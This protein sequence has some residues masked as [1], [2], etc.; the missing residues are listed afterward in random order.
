M[1]PNLQS[2]Y[3][4]LTDV[5][6][7]AAQYG[8]GSLL[9][10]AGPG[11]GK[12]RVLTARIVRLLS[13][14]EG[15]SWRIA[16]LTFTTRAADE[17]RERVLHHLPD[18]EDR[19]F[20]GTFHSFACELLRQ[21]GTHVGIKTNFTIYSEEQSR[22]E[23]LRRALSE[24]GV[25]YDGGLEQALAAID[26]MKDRLIAPEDAGAHLRDPSKSDIFYAIYTA[27]ERTLADRNALDF[28]SLIYG[29]HQL[30][31]R[32]PAIAE[33]YRRSYRELLIDEFQDTNG[34]QY[35]LLRDFTGNDYKNVF[36]VAD[37]DQIIYQW[38]GASHKR[39]SEFREHYSPEVLQMPTNFRCP[40]EVVGMANLLVAHNALRS[41]GKQPLI[42]GKATSTD[43]PRVR[44]LHF[45]SDDDEAAGIANDIAENRSPD[46]S[47]VVLARTKALLEKAQEALRQVGLKSRI[48]Q[49][50]DEFVSKPFQAL[51]LA[52]HLANRPTD[53]RIFQLFVAASNSVLHADIDAPEVVAVAQ[54][55][56]G[57][58]F[59]T[60]VA[61]LTPG[62]A[63]YEASAVAILAKFAE[64][65]DFRTFSRDWTQWIEGEA[66]SLD[67]E[68]PGLDEDR[69]AWSSLYRD[70]N[71]TVG[72][73]AALDTFLQ[74]LVLRSKEPA[75]M[76]DEIPLL[77]IHGSKGNEFDHVYLLGL[78][79]E[80]LPSFQ[81][82]RQGPNSPQM[83][84]ERRNCFVAI[85]RCMETLTLS[86]ADTYRNYRK[87]RSRFLGEM[88]L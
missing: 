23:L 59:R 49:R 2:L 54:S 18:A 39:L 45:A 19:L 88:G 70:I 56:T 83:E 52:L 61:E 82:R 66:Q 36:A 27:Y 12:T 33:K 50:R 30:L 22:L 73:Q 24:C 74:E 65:R 32:Y 1:G 21:N 15:E 31:T 72:P 86:Y 5:Q 41:P 76:P 43:G 16:A 46:D 64:D 71:Q 85:T 51:H 6:T 17:M 84:E 37:D 7:A 11:S 38:N 48:A 14:S 10:L 68:H 80:I 42:P 29:A 47:V 69:R 63:S 87:D 35:Q 78:A 3:A 44:L 67:E 58:L 26:R 55:A 9:L 8:G 28:P 57:D 81:S 62:A 20:V 34:A 4:T 13:Y 40:A 77:T 75:L 53:Q 25:E 79:E 60:W